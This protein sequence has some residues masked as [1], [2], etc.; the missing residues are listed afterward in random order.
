MKPTNVWRVVDGDS[1][2]GSRGVVKCVG[3]VARDESI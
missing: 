3:S 2:D 1:E